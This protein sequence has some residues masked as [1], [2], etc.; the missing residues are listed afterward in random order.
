MII[1]IHGWG[2]F[3]KG[4]NK[5]NTL[6]EIFPDEI[7]ISED[8]NLHKWDE[9]I[10]AISNSIIDIEDTLLFVGSSTGALYAEYCAKRFN[11]KSLLI[12]PV[13]STEQLF[14]FLGEN[15]NYSQLGDFTFTTEMLADMINPVFNNSISRLVLL[16]KNDEVIPS[17]IAHDLY[18]NIANVL[19]NNKEDHRFNDLAAYK[20]EIYE[21]YM[22][23][24]L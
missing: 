10:T 9:T 19:I 22:G 4:S 5:A 8:Y 15:K 3:G 11:G 23:I 1:Y 12:N 14:Q 2:S 21:I 20:R 24:M 17:N 6:N 13:T 18:K 7:V 16:A